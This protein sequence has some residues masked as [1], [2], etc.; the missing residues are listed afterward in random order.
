MRKFDPVFVLDVGF[1][2]Q[3]ALNK[4]LDVESNKPLERN[5]TQT[6]FF[7][8]FYKEVGWLC[9]N[10]SSWTFTNRI[11]PFND[12]TLC[13]FVEFFLHLKKLYMAINFKGVYQFDVIKTFVF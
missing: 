4:S 10:Y 13:E 3:D 11:H 6:F 2:L 12:K 5:H 7:D 1:E 9:R 8:F